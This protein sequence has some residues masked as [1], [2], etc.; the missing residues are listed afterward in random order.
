MNTDSNEKVLLSII[1]IN[2][3]NADGLR[4]TIE[5]VCS[6]AFND[7][8]HI[9]VDGGSKDGSADVIREFLEEEKFKE[10]K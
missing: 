3:N 4:K 8:E 10:K 9:I 7:Y 1:T 2:Y 6:Q 5:S